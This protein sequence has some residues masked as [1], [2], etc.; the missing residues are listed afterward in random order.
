MFRHLSSG[1]RYEVTGEL[2]AR[3]SWHADT[4]LSLPIYDRIM[5]HT[6][7]SHTSKKQQVSFLAV[8]TR[9][10]S[11]L[12][13]RGETGISQWGMNG[14]RKARSKRGDQDRKRGRMKMKE[15]GRR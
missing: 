7:K 14:R 15:E 8:N 4:R 12:W 10:A 13:L 6:E 9:D 1:I 2:S 5:S 3:D 11:H